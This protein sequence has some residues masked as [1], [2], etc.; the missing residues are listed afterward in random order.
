MRYRILVPYTL[1]D[2]GVDELKKWLLQSPNIN[3]QAPALARYKSICKL[4]TA[5]SA[6]W[7]IARKAVLAAPFASFR[8]SHTLKQGREKSKRK[9]C[10]SL[11]GPTSDTA[12]S[13]EIVG[14][15]PFSSPRQDDWW[16]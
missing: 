3:V 6:R 14:E 16:R 8:R 4:A 10:F 13:V 15:L 11:S 2:Y 1:S 7:R 12:L 9:S 5:L